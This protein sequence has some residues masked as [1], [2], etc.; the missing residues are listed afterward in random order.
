M[1]RSIPLFVG[2]KRIDV[3][4]ER[5]RKLDTSPLILWKNW[6]CRSPLPRPYL[7]LIGASTWNGKARKICKS[8]RYTSYHGNTPKKKTRLS[9]K[10]SKKQNSR[11]KHEISRKLKGEILI[12]RNQRKVIKN[13]RRSLGITENDINLEKSSKMSINQSSRR[14]SKFHK[15]LGNI[16]ALFHKHSWPSA[17]LGPRSP[18]NGI[19]W[20]L[21]PRKALKPTRSKIWKLRIVPGLIS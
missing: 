20:I 13:D 15:V 14:L 12:W 3:T 5:R 8:H 16:M 11:K 17:L 2:T 18:K 6:N 10:S 4:S 7:M 9:L 1:E 19:F 21:A